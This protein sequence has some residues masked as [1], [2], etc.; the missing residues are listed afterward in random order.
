MPKVEKRRMQFCCILMIG[1]RNDQWHLR[2]N[3]TL[4]RRFTSQTSSQYVISSDDST[5]FSFDRN[6][7]GFLS[8]RIA[9]LDPTDLPKEVE[10]HLVKTCKE[11][12]RWWTNGKRIHGFS[13]FSSGCCIVR[14]RRICHDD[15]IT[16]YPSFDA[17]F[18]CSTGFGQYDYESMPFRARMGCKR[19]PIDRAEIRSIVRSL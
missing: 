3:A 15:Q 2:W 1:F 7:Q 19:D 11:V 16:F 5:S 4:P 18:S 14:C 8:T 6:F 12:W 17:K 13:I 10:E 9:T